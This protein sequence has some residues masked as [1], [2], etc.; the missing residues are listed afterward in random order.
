MFK[1]K[2][3]FFYNL[4]LI[5]II[6]PNSFHTKLKMYKKRTGMFPVPNRIDVL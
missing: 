5:H 3:Q 4:Y 1:T 2:Q 6:R